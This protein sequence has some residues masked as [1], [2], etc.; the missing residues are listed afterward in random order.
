MLVRKK[1][2]NNPE[3]AE[4]YILVLDVESKCENGMLTVY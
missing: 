1:D 4:K 3:I 2:L